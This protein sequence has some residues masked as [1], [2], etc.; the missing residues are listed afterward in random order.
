MSVTF[1]DSFR[2]VFELARPVLRNL[3]VPGTVFV[4]TSFVGSGRPMQWSGITTWLDGPNESELIP[5]SWDELGELAWRAGRSAHT[6]ARIRGC[7]ASTGSRCAR[8][9]PDRKPTSRRASAAAAGRSPTRTATA[10]RPSPAAR[11]AGVGGGAMAGRVVAAGRSSG[12][13]PVFLADDERRYRSRSPGRCV[14][15][16][17]RLVARAPAR[18]GPASD[19]GPIIVG[20]GRCGSTLLHRPRATTSWAGCPR[21][22]RCSWGSP[23]LSPGLY[24]PPL[25]DRIRHLKAFPKPFEAYRFWEHYPGFSRRDRPPTAA[26][27]P[28]AGIEPARRATDRVLRFRAAR[29][30]W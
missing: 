26:D 24:E 27:V 29:A 2:S 12:R 1:D 7:P 8:S 14:G 15:C 6:P 16:A 5:M 11:E 20:T 9:S 21:S 23:G 19:G 17:D 10:R 22:T 13:V 4:P 25:G 18:A 28:A 30:C 3:G